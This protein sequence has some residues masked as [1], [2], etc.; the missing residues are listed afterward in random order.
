MAVGRRSR[1]LI[2]PLLVVNFVVCLIVLGLAGWSLDEYI[3]GEQNHPHLGGNSSTSFMLIFA[4]IAGVV[5]ACSVLPGLVHLRAWRSDSL[6]AAGSLAVLSW[7]ITA[8]AFGLVCKEIIL[9]GRRIKRL[10]TLEFFIFMSLLSQL[11]YVGVLHAG[12][13]D[14]SYGPGYRSYD[15]D[16]DHAGGGAAMGHEPQNPG[17]SDII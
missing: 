17:T 5:G 6:A 1:D 13:F 15:V 12:V 10:Q 16:N 9:G 4:L 3:D 14:N 8:L 7:A 2:G 11:L